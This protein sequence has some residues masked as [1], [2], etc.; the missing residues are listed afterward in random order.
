MLLRSFLT[1]ITRLSLRFR[2]ITILVTVAALVLGVIAGIQ[3]N[4][5]FLPNIEFPQ[6]FVVT[7]RPGASSE[8]LRD[9]VTIR[10]SKPSPPSKAS[11][12]RAWSRPPAR[13][14]RS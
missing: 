11:S 2:W 13:P 5:E 6:T 1:A 3:L 4:Q 14:S 7:L 8:D 10:W 12:R 9:L